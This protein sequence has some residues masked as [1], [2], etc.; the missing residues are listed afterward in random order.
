MSEV[1]AALV[2]GRPSPFTLDELAAVSRVTF[3]V[4]ESAASGSAIRLQLEK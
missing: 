1:V 4:A 2:Q 3:A